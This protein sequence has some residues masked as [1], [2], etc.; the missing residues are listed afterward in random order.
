MTFVANSPDYATCTG[1]ITPNKQSVTFTT[2]DGLPDQEIVY[3]PVNIRCADASGHHIE[4]KVDTWDGALQANLNS[5][6]VTMYNGATKEGASI[7]LYPTGGGTSITTTGIVPIAD[8]NIWN[9]E[10]KVYW[11]S[12]AAVGV[13]SVHVNL[14]LVVAD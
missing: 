11:K 1:S 5:I 4:L 13:D 2:M 8:G 9:V 12:T 6:T 3:M 10:W 7:V 14:L